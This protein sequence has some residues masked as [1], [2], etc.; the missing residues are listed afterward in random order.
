MS[1]KANG[2]DLAI[3]SGVII[4]SAT[5]TT[6]PN[7]YVIANGQPR[8]DTSNNKYTNLHNLGIGTIANSYFLSYK[9]DNNVNNTGSK[10]NGT[11]YG[12]ATYNS[13]VVKRGAYS[14]LLNSTSY[15]SVPTLYLNTF[16]NGISIAFWFYRT[17][18]GTSTIF[19]FDNGSTAVKCIFFGNGTPY[20]LYLNI[21][22]YP[23]QVFYTFNALNTW[24]HFAATL[25]YTSNN[26]SVCKIYVN[27]VL[28]ST[29][30]ATMSY[31][32]EPY[33]D[34]N[35]IGD[36]TGT[37]MIGYLD[38][39]N[40]YDS[41]LSAAN[42]TNLYNTGVGAV[43]VKPYL[44]YQFEQ[45]IT[46]T[47]KYLDGTLFGT[48]TY[49]SSVVKRG[50]HSLLLNSTS[51]VN[52]PLMYLNT[53]TNGI[54]IAFWFYR[55]ASGTSTIFDFDNG[56][57]LIDCYFFG[58]STPYNLY[59]SVGTSA[60][61][62]TFNTLNVWSH[63]A[64]TLTYT[65]NDTSVCK[66]YVNGVLQSTSGAGMKYPTGSYY[67][68]NTI[69]N[70]SGTSM[71]GY[72]DDF[73]IYNTVLTDSEVTSVYNN[74]YIGDLYTPPNLSAAFLRSTGS[75]T[76]V[77]SYTGPSSKSFQH[78]SIQQHNHTGSATHTHST[79]S[80]ANTNG[81]DN[82]AGAIGMGGCNSFNTEASANN[83]N[84]TNQVNVFQ[85]YD[86]SFSIAPSQSITV[87]NN[88]GDSNENAPFCYGVNWLIKL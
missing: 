10:L 38:D 26:T 18:D 14:L 39:F 43:T 11:L 63:F 79:A 29:S 5:H 28:Q 58:G 74:T 46:D 31:P 6:D 77:N 85:L 13:S 54:S 33:Y 57:K 51:Y 27:G 17:V 34:N 35:K 1:F 61:F 47:G 7:G 67:S 73:N 80:T 23:S 81:A 41:V 15:I 12:T 49:N 78:Y 60:V 88:T 16:I 66:V 20:N 45:N 64:I 82:A 70:T 22:N 21:G 55:T 42:V 9:F 44:S 84:D 52:V 37:S 83:S 25:T 40:I 69:G 24:Y 75:Q 2:I 71:V 62:Y 36:A 59:F 86:V 8:K 48:A 53:F 30:S 76:I 32:T 65:S 50:T 68:N 19:N 3:P 72:I 4:A 56:S 87:S